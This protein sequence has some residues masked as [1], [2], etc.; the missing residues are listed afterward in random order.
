MSNGWNPI[1]WAFLKPG[2]G[3]SFS[4]I[5]VR[6]ELQLHHYQ[7]SKHGIMDEWKAQKRMYEY[8]KYET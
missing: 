8:D 3:K 5:N 6:C 2:N 1:C 7:R 4:N